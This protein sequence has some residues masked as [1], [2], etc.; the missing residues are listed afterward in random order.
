MTLEQSSVE[1]EH[2]HHT[3][4]GNDIP[5]YVRLIWVFFWIFVI[6]YGITYFLPEIDKELLSPP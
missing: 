1:E 2:K 4:M 3:Y 5:W 6:Y